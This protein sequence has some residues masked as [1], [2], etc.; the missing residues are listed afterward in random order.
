MSQKQVN[1]GGN[2]TL[3]VKVSKST[4][5]LLNIL[6]EG[7]QHGTNANDLLKMFCHAFIESAKHT[8]PVS[9][10]MQQLL[11]MLKIDEGFHKAFN[12]ADPNSQKR[13]AHVVLILEQPGREGL[14]MVQIDRPYLPDQKPNITYCVDSILEY[15][16]K[17]GMKGLYQ[18]LC[19]IGNE[20]GT[21]SLRDTLLKLIEDYRKHSMWLQFEEEGPQLGNY[22]DFG[23]AIEYAQRTKRKMRRTVDGE[24]MRQ[25]RIFDPDRPYGEQADEY[26]RNLEER[27]KEEEESDHD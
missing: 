17:V 19:D 14:G 12:F 24:A 10:E 6:A 1:D 20:I 3:S 27:A 22:S 18:Q 11:N 8:G 25:L 23:R 5:Q 15:V 7:L 2:A 21:Q 13:I 4:Y 26:L 16:T 9:P